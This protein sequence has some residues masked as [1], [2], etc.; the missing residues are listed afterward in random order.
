MRYTRPEPDLHGSE[1]LKPDQMPYRWVVLALLW[2]LYFSFG[3]TTRSIAPLVTPILKDLNMNYSQMGTILGS[4]QLTYILVSIF[5][6]TIIDQWGL[7]KSLFAGVVTIGLTFT[8][9]IEAT[10]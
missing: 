7:R 3:L 6:G 1:V 4:W 9:K 8:L 10:A 5:A 2:F